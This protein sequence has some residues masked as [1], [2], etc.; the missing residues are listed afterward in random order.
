MAEAS[1]PAHIV[2][3]GL[4][5]SGKTTV[6]QALADALD[7]PLRDS[8]ADLL[9]QTGR[10]A[11]DIAAQDGM[12]AL[13]AME[14]AHL[15]DALDAPE[16]AVIIAAASVIDEPAGRAALASPG[17]RVAWLRIDPATAV[18]RMRAGSHRPDHDLVAQAARRD[19][20]FAAVADVTAD[21]TTEDA[22]AIAADILAWASPVEPTR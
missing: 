8:D 13:H 18:R 15:L 19:P 1:S 6:G 20:W 17:V 14:L 11:R 16:P 10:S 5:A 3:V 9:A 21:A 22:G 7:R 2:V 12:D 4:M